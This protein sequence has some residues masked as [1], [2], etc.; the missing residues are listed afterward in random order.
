MYEKVLFYNEIIKKW[1]LYEKI[2][3]KYLLTHVS[4]C[5]SIGIRYFTAKL[6]INTK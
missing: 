5:L 3:T 2:F 1:A 4:T 6:N